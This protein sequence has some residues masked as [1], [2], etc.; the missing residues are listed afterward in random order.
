VHAN[1]DFSISEFREFRWLN[2]PL[3]DGNRAQ[4]WF[5]LT[6]VI[7]LLFHFTRADHSQNRRT[8]AG[9]G[10]GAWFGS[11]MKSATAQGRSAA[12]GRLPRSKEDLTLLDAKNTTPSS[13]NKENEACLDVTTQLA[14]VWQN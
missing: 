10:S 11:G 14:Q 13:L 8:R 7:A 5:E 1:D 6:T 12:E 9:S 3:I 4:L 2:R